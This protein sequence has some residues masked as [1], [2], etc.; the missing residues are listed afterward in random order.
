MRY[1]SKSENFMVA[2][3]PSTCVKS[4]MLWNAWVFLLLVWNHFSDEI[5]KRHLANCFT[6]PDKILPVV[7]VKHIVSMEDQI[8]H[9]LPSVYQKLYLYSI[10][11]ICFHKLFQ[12][13][14]CLWPS[15]GMSL[16]K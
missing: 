7:S 15:K 1:V 6:M 9:S 10:M 2:S 12:S 16:K 5:D 8:G 11:D 13:G 4:L 14:F 3:N